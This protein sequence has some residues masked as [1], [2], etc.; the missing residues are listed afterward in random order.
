MLCI[1]EHGVQGNY[2]TCI[3]GMLDVCM[4][5]LGELCVFVDGE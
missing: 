5:K 3:V 2:C 1:Y 4:C